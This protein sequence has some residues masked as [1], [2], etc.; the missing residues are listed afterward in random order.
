[1]SSASEAIIQI[2]GD[3]R[4][5]AF[6]VAWMCEELRLPWTLEATFPW[7]DK[8]YD[9]NPLGKVPVI[10]DGD[11][12]LYESAAILNYLADK[13]QETA[14]LQLIPK[15][16]TKE[17]ALY[18][19]FLMVIFTDLESCGLWTH[20]KFVDLALH[21]R[22]PKL[23]EELQYIHIAEA[24]EPA[25]HTFDRALKILTTQLEERKYL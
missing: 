2:Y 23:M 6:R 7:T 5:R 11:F 14:G 17:R 21:S 13:Y 18:D 22:N 10:K 16:G 19:Q 1:M 24:A 4:I 12:Y 25:K 20:R 15:V 8:M 9:V 3:L